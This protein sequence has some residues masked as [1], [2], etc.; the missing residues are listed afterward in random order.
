MRAILRQNWQNWLFLVIFWLSFLPA[1]AQQQQQK[2]LPSL[3]PGE[4]KALLEGQAWLNALRSV[5]IEFE[6]INPDGSRWPGRMALDRGNARLRI[7]YDGDVP[8]KIIARRGSVLQI[9]TELRQISNWPA[10]RTPANFLLEAP[11]RFDNDDFLYRWILLDTATAPE[12]QIDI[13]RVALTEDAYIDQ[14]ILEL[15]F[16]L[17]PITLR[18]WRIYNSAGQATIISLKRL[19]R[20]VSFRRSFFEYSFS[21]E[22]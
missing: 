9:D 1:H 21:Q 15:L 14:G 3:S 13:L 17:E 19:T 7:D 4:A 20:G 5:V 2:G 8:L 11:F 18:E 6:Q 16:S 12:G 22:R 10:S